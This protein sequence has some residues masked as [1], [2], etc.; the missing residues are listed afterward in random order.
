LLGTLGP[1]LATQKDCSVSLS[2]GV[3]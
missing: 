3:F 1:A 2:F